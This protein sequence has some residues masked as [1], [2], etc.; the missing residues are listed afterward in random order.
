MSK[1]GFVLA[2]PEHT[3]VSQECTKLDWKLCFL[4]GIT[5]P[6]SVPLSKPFARQGYR[7]DDPETHGTYKTI[8]NCLVEWQEAGYL[9]SDMNMK[10]STVTAESSLPVVQTL[11]KKLVENQAIFHKKCLVKYGKEKLKRKQESKKETEVG[12]SPKKTRRSFTAINFEQTCFFCDSDDDELISCR[13]SNLSKH[14]R[15][16]SEYLMDARLLQN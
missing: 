2:S 7:Q 14:V 1:P 10:I 3:S 5:E 9:S 16:W 11:Q 12:T 8:S 4:C 13:T 15:E 6:K